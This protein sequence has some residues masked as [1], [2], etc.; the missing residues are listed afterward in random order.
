MRY[1]I[2]AILVFSMVIMTTLSPADA[3]NYN[4]KK[5]SKDNP[6]YA[7]LVMD[8]DTGKILSQRYSTK[9]LHPASLTKM[10]T[11]LLTFEALDRGEIRK[12]T[13]VRI[14]TRAASMVPSKLGLPAGSA[15]KIEDA[16][17]ALATKSAN[18]VAVALAEHLGGSEPRFAQGMTERARTIGMK[19][20]RFKN[21]SGL[22]H[23]QQV[24]T[25]RDMAKLAQHILKRY[26]HHY[27]YFS[28]RSFTYRGKTYRNHNRLLDSFKGMD[29]FKTGYIN[30]SGFN[31][32]ASARQGGRR[33]IGVV[34]GGRSGATRNAHM[35]E[36]MTAGFK[37]ARNSRTATFMTEPPTPATKPTYGVAKLAPRAPQAQDS[38]AYASLASLSKKPATKITSKLPTPPKPKSKNANTQKNYTAL[39]DALKTGAFSEMIGEGDIDPSV[40]KRLETGLI[41][42]AVHKGEY[43]PDP[44]PASQLEKSLRAAGHAM[45]DKMGQEKKVA[46]PAPTLNNNG[47]G[48][49][50]PH[51]KDVVG[52]WSVQIGAY[53]SR[54]KTDNALRAAKENLP[55]HLA[56]VNAMTVPL[57]TSNGTIF[58][59]RL[60][61]VDEAQARNL[62]QYF[63]DCIP[64]APIAT[65]VSAAK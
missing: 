42:V 20:T 25:A 57:N 24:T 18:D 34:F 60:G 50:L 14:S 44:E 41:A 22:H 40:S 61:G 49:S 38:A 4:K 8:A 31:L 26:P 58:R 56:N 37:K 54:L 12:S 48:T 10:M 13:R 55:P 11:L 43:R 28:T 63:K 36:I 52:K 62:C 17:K 64:V 29:G 3:R 59:A 45:V 19:N 2:F 6:K 21:A 65:R 47:G 1:A 46:S 27:K 23:N 16:I 35:A 9:S 51:P 5:K 53:K 7:S 39:T 33:L 15:I 32:V 30:A